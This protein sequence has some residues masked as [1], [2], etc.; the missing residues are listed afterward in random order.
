MRFG[1]ASQ[2]APS[3]NSSNCS[4]MLGQALSPVNPEPALLGFVPSTRESASETVLERAARRAVT[5]LK[6]APTSW[7]L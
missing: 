6:E 5:Y 2:A 1:G 3:S 7:R 4:M